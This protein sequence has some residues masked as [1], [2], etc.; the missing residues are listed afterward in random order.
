MKLTEK[1]A[2][3]VLN[4]I[5]DWANPSDDIDEEMKAD[6]VMLELINLELANN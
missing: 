5:L 3:K 4:K 2:F 1:Q 6:F